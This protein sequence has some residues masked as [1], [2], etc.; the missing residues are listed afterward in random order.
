MMGIKLIYSFILLGT[1]YALAPGRN[2]PLRQLVVEKGS[3]TSPS[4]A[5]IIDLSKDLPED[6]AAM[7]FSEGAK[8][9][10]QAAIAEP[11]IRAAIVMENGRIV[12][13]YYRKDVTP[14][15]VSPIFSGTKSWTSLLIGLL[16]DD[17]LLSVDQTLGEIF[18]DDVAWT[19]VTDGSED[20]RKNVT[21]EELLTMTSG[22]LDPPDAPISFLLG[23]NVGG[24][25]LSDSLAYPDIGEKG[26][27][28]YL[29]F[30]YILSYVIFK[31]TGMTPGEL[32][33][34][35]V[36][37]HLGIK[38]DDYVWSKNSDGLENAFTGLEVTPTM[39][40][41][42]GQLY[43]QKGLAG[44]YEEQRVV[45]QDW[46]EASFTRHSNF[47]PSSYPNPVRGYLEAA[48]PVFFAEQGEPDAYYGFFFMGHP[49]KP[50]I[51]CSAG[52]GANDLCIDPDN[53]RVVLQ[54]TDFHFSSI[55]DYIDSATTSVHPAFDEVFKL[56]QIG[57]DETLSFSAPDV[58]DNASHEVNG[59]GGGGEMEFPKS[60]VNAIKNEELLNSGVIRHVS[61]ATF[62]GLSAVLN[63]LL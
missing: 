25:S 27:V 58:V 4:A 32:L 42:L 50:N 8:A 55:R 54:Q 14:S 16:V 35:R 57:L 11:R 15:D 29:S 40:V 34:E 60:A 39:L 10:E 52:W 26:K 18:P 31:L 51:F 17:G 1:S 33:A 56:V 19:D 44:P 5:T 62:F 28:T 22:L 53:K 20:F 41:K 46:V 12:S 45:S 30:S 49:S 61:L 59:T 23:T 37:P 48:M 47:Y 6:T 36:M 9:M 38:V 43:M 24:S 13:S 63:C 3:D 21:I 7:E 2:G